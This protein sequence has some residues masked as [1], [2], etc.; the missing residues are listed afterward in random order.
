MTLNQ[1]NS[2]KSKGMSEENIGSISKPSSFF[3]PIFVNHYM[4]QDVNL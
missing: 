2:W 1:F 3:A 4:L